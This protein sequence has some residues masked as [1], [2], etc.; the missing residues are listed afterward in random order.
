MSWD[1]YETPYEP[2]YD[3][4]RPGDDP[5]VQVIFE[6]SF[7]HWVTVRALK[8]LREAGKIGSALEELSPKTPLRFYF[9]RRCRYW[10]RKADDVRRLVLAFSDQA[11]TRALEVQGEL[12]IDAGLPQVRFLPAGREV[13]AWEGRA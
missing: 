8:E 5:A 3:H 9:S 12:L 10:R 13:R 6:R 4:P 11:F 2:D 7:F 1:D